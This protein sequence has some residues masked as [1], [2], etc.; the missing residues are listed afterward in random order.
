[1]HLNELAGVGCL[2]HAQ[3]RDSTVLIIVIVHSQRII[4]VN[5]AKPLKT[6]T[7]TAG[8]NN[9]PVWEDEEWIKKYAKPLGQEGV[10]K[11]EVDAGE[12]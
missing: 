12:S 10:G 2:K 5:I 6:S 7:N 8:Y 11:P 9:R 4:N 3:R 1:M